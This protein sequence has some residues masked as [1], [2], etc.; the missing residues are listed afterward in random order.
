MRP[1]MLVV[2][3]ALKLRTPL[4]DANSLINMIFLS[5]HEIWNCVV[6]K[7]LVYMGLAAVLLHG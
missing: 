3:M 7:N 6:G 5:P 1:N 4:L 2:G